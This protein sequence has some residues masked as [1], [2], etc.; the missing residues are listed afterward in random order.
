MLIIISIEGFIGNIKFFYIV[1]HSITITIKG[2]VEF[3]FFIHRNEKYSELQLIYK[4]YVIPFFINIFS[5]KII[6]GVEEF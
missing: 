4:L 5:S 2:I 1:S 6:P 3:I